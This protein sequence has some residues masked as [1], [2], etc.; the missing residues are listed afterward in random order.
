MDYI[1]HQ[2]LQA[3]I[4]EWVTISFSRGSSQPRD[5]TQVSYIAGR[6]FQLSRQGSPRILEW[7]AYPFS[8]GSSRPRNWT[9]ASCIAGGFF[10][11]NCLVFSFSPKCTILWFLIYSWICNHH[12]DLITEHFHYSK[13]K[14]CISHYPQSLLLLDSGNH[15]STFCLC[16]FADSRHFL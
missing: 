9:G 10:T 8:R 3:R 5:R 1:V 15:L 14:L 2:I 13:K 7:A 4:L 6:F 12:H 11:K 16:G